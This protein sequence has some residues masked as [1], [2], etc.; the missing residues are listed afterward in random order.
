[1]SEK[2]V[3]LAAQLRIL[4]Y[5]TALEHTMTIELPFREHAINCYSS[6]PIPPSPVL[7]AANYS[8]PEPFRNISI[9]RFQYMAPLNEVVDTTTA[10]R[11]VT[12]ISIS[13][14][15]D[16]TNSDDQLL[17]F[18]PPVDQCVPSLRRDVL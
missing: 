16:G 10:V 5:Q 12:C 15:A 17:L 7:V 6:P 13:V 18:P 9:L 11:K 2:K 14:A 3:M 8:C 4:A 1:M